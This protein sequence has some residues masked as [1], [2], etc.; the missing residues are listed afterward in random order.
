MIFTMFVVPHAYH[1]HTLTLVD[2]CCSTTIGRYT[3]FAPPSRT[4]SQLISRFFPP[5]ILSIARI[6]LST[7]AGCMNFQNP[8]WGN[9]HR[10]SNFLPEE[11]NLSFCS[12]IPI[13]SVHIY[14]SLKTQNLNY[15]NTE[16]ME[17]VREFYATPQFIDGKLVDGAVQGIRSLKQMGFKLAIV[18]ARSATMK[19]QTE[20]WVGRHFPGVLTPPIALRA[21]SSK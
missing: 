16:T 8:G 15:H 5:T 1:M 14:L 18:T 6:Q 12:S 17:K 10:E 4:T 21:A 7:N 13:P 19:E 11:V 3:H 9:P 20:D 2:L